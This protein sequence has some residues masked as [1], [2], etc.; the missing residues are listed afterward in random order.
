L[1]ELL[2]VIPLDFPEHRHR[3]RFPLAA[4]AVQ[5]R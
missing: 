4:M 3:R 1:L 2:Y 5:Y